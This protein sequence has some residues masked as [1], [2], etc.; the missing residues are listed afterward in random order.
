MGAAMVDWGN[1]FRTG[2]VIAEQTAYGVI[3]A[4]WEKLDDNGAYQAIND[5]VRQSSLNQL[6]GMDSALSA[7]AATR[8]D[9]GDRRRLGRFYAFFK[10]VETDR[11]GFR[12]FAP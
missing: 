9:I 8:F 6:S 4:Q 10:I 11:H 5:Y 2:I 3:V 12:G 7:A 1:V